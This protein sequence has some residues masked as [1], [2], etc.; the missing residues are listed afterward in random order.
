[1]KEV[2]GTL[3][4]NQARSRF[5]EDLWEDLFVS[6]PH[7][8]GRLEVEATPPIAPCVAVVISVAAL[9]SLT[10]DRRHL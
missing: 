1:M 10:G 6:K 2:S 8:R 4:R 7:E 3:A 5:Q 9:A